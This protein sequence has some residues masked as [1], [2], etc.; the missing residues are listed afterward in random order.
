MKFSIIV[1]VYNVE[2]YLDDCIG[3]VL[4][5][6]YDDLEIIL[7]DDGSTDASGMI[8]DRYAADH[9]ARVKVIHRSNSGALLSRLTALEIIT[10]DA[11][12]FLDSDDELRADTLSVLRETFESGN[13]DLVLYNASSEKDRTKKI[14]DFPFKDNSSFEGEEKDKL[15][16][17]LLVK[18]KL[19]NIWLKAMKRDIALSLCSL[20][21]V[22]RLTHGED[23]LMSALAV[24]E[25]KRVVYKE[26]DLYFYRSRNGSIVHTTDVQRYL[27]V[28]KVHC[29]VEK[30]IKQYDLDRFSAGHYAREVKS[31]I[32]SVMLLHKSK[33]EIGKRK[34]NSVIREMSRDMFFRSAFEKMDRGE[35]SCNFI[36]YA[37]LLYNEALF[38]LTFKLSVRKAVLDIRDKLRR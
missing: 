29:E 19:N 23:L 8:C 12:V 4:K 5:Q 3:S 28:K 7:V 27:C 38:I 16:E 30:L 11:V 22:G 15:Y 10:G 32:I 2:A 37:E 35:L 24:M 6:T 13:C 31:F 9:P 26:R 36:S 1:P 33:H 34:Y 17:L 20:S 21:Y 25:A 14:Y 18:G